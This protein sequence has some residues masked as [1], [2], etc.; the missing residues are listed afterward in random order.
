[1][2]VGTYYGFNAGGGPTGVGAATARSMV[3]NLV[4]IHVLGATLSIGFWGL[5]GDLPFGG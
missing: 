3:V 4:L 5:S 2:T 1:M